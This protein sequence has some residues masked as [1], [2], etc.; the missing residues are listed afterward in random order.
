MIYGKKIFLYKHRLQSV[1]TF[2]N[3]NFYFE[4]S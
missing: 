3:D 4:Q 2:N 1:D